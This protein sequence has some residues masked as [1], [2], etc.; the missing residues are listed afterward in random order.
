MPPR[1]PRNVDITTVMDAVDLGMVNADLWRQVGLLTKRLEE[2]NQ[3]QDDATVMEENSWFHWNT[4]PKRC[5]LHWGRGFLVDIP[6]FDGGLKGDE[7]I[8]W[9]L[10]VEEIL[11][12]EKA[13]NVQRVSLVAIHL[14]GRP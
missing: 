13:P 14:R 11:D 4:S 5:D 1:K 12:F 3:V 2:L 8:D 6:D 9:L 7:F 10:Q